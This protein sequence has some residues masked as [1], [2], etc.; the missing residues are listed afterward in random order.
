VLIPYPYITN[1]GFTVDYTLTPTTFVE[2]VYGS[3]KNELA[4]GGSGGILVNDSANRLNGMA[5]F[6]LLYPDAG[7]VDPRYYQL[8]ALTRTGAIYFDGTSVNLPPLFNWGNLIAGGPPNQQYPGWLNVNK[9]QD[10]AVSITKVAGHHTM[11]AGFYNNHS[12]KAQN[13]GAGG[14][15]S[16]QGTVN[17]GE[18]SNNPLD[19][20]F[21]YA[22]A[23]VGVFD[24][25]QQASQLIEGNMIYN[26]TEFYL[27][28]NWK[29]TPRWTL[30]YGMRFTHQQPQYD[31]FGQ[32]SG[33]FPD[34]WDAS[35]APVLYVPGCKSGVYPCSGN[36]RNAMNPLTGEILTIPNAN[37]SSAFI[38]TVVPNSGNRLNGIIAAGQGI[39][40]TGYTWPSMV[41]GP[42]FGT[43]YDLS[44]DQR[45]VV[46]GGVGLFYDR[47]DGNTVF[48][49][50]SNP[51]FADSQ[52]LRN[53]N[54]RDLAGAV[55]TVGT[56]D[57]ITF[58][59]DADIPSSVQWNAGIQMVL[60]WSSS[61]D[62][63]YVG[64][65]G[66]NM[67]GGFQGGNRVDLNSIDLGAAYLPENQDPTKSSTVPGAAALPDV[68]LRTYRGLNAIGQN[69]TGF[70]E[71]YHSIQA[72]LNRRFVNGLSFG[73]NY[74]LGLSFTGNTGLP[75]NVQR[76]Q[77]SPDGTVS[78]RADNAQWEDLM[79]NLD[80]R[81]HTIVANAVWDLPDM[82]ADS[83]GKRVV[84]AILN[85]WQL[86]G[87]L[88][89]G[90]AGAYDLSYSYQRDGASV[91]LTGSSSFP[92]RIVYTGDPGSGCSD[93]QYAQFNAS[94]VA[95]PTYFS[96]GLESGRNLLRNC[97]NK[98]V[99]LALVRNFRLGGGRQA[100]V[101]VDAFNAFN[102][103]IYNNSQ[104]QLQLT[105]P[106]D[107]GIRN[108]EFLADGSVN[109]DKTQPKSA[110]FGAVTSAQ[111][112]RTVQLTFR[113]SF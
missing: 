7:R 17:F 21:G 9:T 62:L 64:S 13:T 5:D 102:V 27:Q 101:R 80:L 82:T 89:A 87:V 33:F 47:P 105:N 25:Y 75:G 90:S 14:A 24:R 74:T 69:T 12:F 56:P 19:T 43:A 20:G 11:K 50:P 60:P 79:K 81:R 67:M 42:R 61:L 55:S 109:P 76:L 112:M 41:F 83:G 32:M 52:D 16:F 18:D 108:S 10:F 51:P 1:Y 48:S 92:A 110:G 31:Q 77:H 91:N 86:S 22:N 40:K 4:G 45:F 54:L 29:V 84:A 37:N 103:L 3:I 8:D 15:G 66:Y 30:D 49:I 65:H 44:G 70:H 68:M 57:L 107:Q 99:D 26:N 35:A 59:Y 2:A 104:R 113:L 96:D 111:N 94:A 97:A 63:S 95:G 38:G 88:S 85:D 36:D 53:G 73:V 106:T 72:S 23:A 93:N 39:A 71:T 34:K 100:Q 6:P 98:T 78:L 46:R 58:Q 28:D